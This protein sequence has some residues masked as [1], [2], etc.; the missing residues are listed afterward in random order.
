MTSKVLIGTSGFGVGRAK[1]V[2]L[3]SCVE[4]Q[5]TF[6]QPPKIATLERWR[7]E[8]PADFEFVL[9]A[10]QLITHDSTSPTYRRLKRQ[11]SE[12]E[13]QEAGY[14]RPTP[15]VKEAW[16]A[17]LACAQA[18]KA[19]A[20]LFQCPA[21]FKPTKEN[22]ANLEKFFAMIRKDKSVEQLFNF[23]WEPRGDWDDT[24][25]REICESLSLSHALD[26]FVTKSVTPHSL[27]FRLHG[28][29]GWR[30]EYEDGELRELAEML[31]KRLAKGNPPYV[32]FNNV[33]MTQDALRFRAIASSKYTEGVE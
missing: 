10:W 32:F 2:E 14:F 15:I 33:R 8:S 17:T 19:G 27:Y 23:Y 25:V 21:S 1:Y 11:L 3:F 13:N 4:V 28:R 6:Y 9:K 18:L 30:Y 7:A 26:P 31:P 12:K 29:G 22:I 24:V 16:E 5:Y 20:I